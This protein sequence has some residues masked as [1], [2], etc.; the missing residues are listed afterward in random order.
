MKP[1]MNSDVT[2]VRKSRKSCIYNPI[3]KLVLILLRSSK[4]QCLVKIIIL[5]FSYLDFLVEKIKKTGRVLKN[6]RW[7]Y[8]SYF[9]SLLLRSALS[10]FSSP[11]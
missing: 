1:Q 2:V 6:A 9:A 3:I 7:R 11:R 8:N 5:D 4:K 10:P